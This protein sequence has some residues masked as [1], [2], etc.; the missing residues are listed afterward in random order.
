MLLAG[1]VDGVSDHNGARWRRA[2][3]SRLAKTPR[4]LRLVGEQGA[5]WTGSRIAH[6]AFGI[7]SEDQENDYRHG[8]DELLGVRLKR[9]VEQDVSAPVR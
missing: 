2:R 5:R 7:L 4:D 6:E 9:F 1:G 3:R 8:W